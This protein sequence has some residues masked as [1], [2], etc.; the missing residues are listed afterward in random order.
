M[1]R[2]EP[3]EAQLIAQLR[4]DLVAERAWSMRMAEY[5]EEV[6]EAALPEDAAVVGWERDEDWQA[7][8][9]KRAEE[10]LRRDD[11][12]RRARWRRSPI[13]VMGLPEEPTQTAPEAPC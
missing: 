6:L 11:W 2:P 12:W 4:A 10:D 13:P 8:W 5:V 1:G 7:Y 3:T 9:S